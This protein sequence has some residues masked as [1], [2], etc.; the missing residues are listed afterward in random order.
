M[1]ET[2]TRKVAALARTETLRADAPALLGYCT[3]F[4]SVIVA[5]LVMH[6]LSAR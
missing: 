1:T 6:G 2:R 4:A 3:L 5:V